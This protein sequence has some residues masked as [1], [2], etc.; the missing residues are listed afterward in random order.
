M[1]KRLN[2]YLFSLL[3][4]L[5]LM[6]TSQTMKAKDVCASNKVYCNPGQCYPVAKALC[7]Q[8]CQNIAAKWNGNWNNT[9]PNCH[10]FWLGQYAVCGCD[11]IPCKCDNGQQ[12]V[13]DESQN[14]GG[15]NQCKTN[16]NCTEGRTCVNGWCQG[17]AYTQCRCTNGK[18]ISCD[19]SKNSGGPGKCRTNCNC[20]TGRHCLNGQ[21]NDSDRC[22]S[23]SD[24][25]AGTI[26]IPDSWGGD[27]GWCE[28]PT[29]C[30]DYC[31][32]NYFWASVGCA[33]LGPINAQTCRER[34]W[35][36][37]GQCKQQCG[38][39]SSETFEGRGCGNSKQSCPAGLRCSPSG[40]C[41]T[42]AEC[43]DSCLQNF[44]LEKKA[45]AKDPASCIKNINGK[46]ISEL[47]AKCR[48]A[49][50]CASEISEKKE[51]TQ[52]KKPAPHSTS[53]APPEVKMEKSEMPPAFPKVPSKTPIVPPKEESKETPSKSPKEK[54]KPREAPSEAPKEKEEPSKRPSEPL[55]EKEKPREASSESPKEKEE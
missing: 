4:A 28:T 18:Q 33:F 12:I 35:D 8:A 49:C 41:Q 9:D 22:I 26:C 45:C 13:C 44:L 6:T 19:E 21:C 37:W 42:S 30:C 38:G 40:Q 32:L 20:G 11:P 24:C 51:E 23:N 14:P 3:I 27:I 25:S 52:K 10:W 29:A 31:W 16:C 5:A 43:C 54:E 1:K 15:P 50:D 17:T 48:E 47:Y 53:V 55:E 7:D 2:L 39:C 34:T 36:F 46:N